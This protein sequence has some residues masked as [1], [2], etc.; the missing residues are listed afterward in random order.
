MTQTLEAASATSAAAPAPTAAPTK[1]GVMPVFSTYIYHCEAGPVHLNTG[2]E[3]L[4]HELMKD[5]RNAARRTNQGGWHYSSDFLALANNLV[6]E[7][8]RHMEA[9]LQGFLNHFRPEA[10]K[11][12]D[13]F[14]LRGW[15]NVNRAGDSNLLHCHPGSFVS[16]VYYVSVPKEMKG[17]EIYFRDP[18][19]PAV[20]MYETPGIE[21]PWIGS[22]IGIPFT[23]AAGLLLMFP[24][25]LE[26]RVAPF[27]GDGERIS[28][29]FNASNPDP[30]T[31]V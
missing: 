19:G 2:L 26:H 9:H 17:G 16:A 7:F 22:G 30:S 1:A 3:L 27:E 25:W 14:L 4:A 10:R 29:A 23:P 11:R 24:A 18:R 15:I 5:P 20:A 21:L 13:H 28:I 8:R 12:K 6:G 31:R